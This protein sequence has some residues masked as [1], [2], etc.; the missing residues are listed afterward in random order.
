M[1][2]INTYNGVILQS[3]RPAQVIVVGASISGL[4]AAYDLQREGV[5]CVVLEARDRIGSKLQDR[6]RAAQYPE[7]WVNTRG[8][9]SWG[10]IL[11]LR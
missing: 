4:Q 3:K 8:H 11:G 9:G 1:E 5:S 10:A 6:A 7:A 2:R